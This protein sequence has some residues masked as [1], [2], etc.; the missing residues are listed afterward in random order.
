MVLCVVFMFVIM[1]WGYCWSDVRR[2]FGYL[3]LEK[4]VKELVWGYWLVVRFFVNMV[5][6]FVCKV[7]LGVVVD[8]SCFFW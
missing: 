5:E 2:F 8:L 4:G 1:V 7:N 3:Y 6:I